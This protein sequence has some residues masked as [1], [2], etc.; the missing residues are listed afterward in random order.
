ML[1]TLF[2]SPKSIGS[3]WHVPAQLH[4]IPGIPSTNFRYNF[5]CFTGGVSWDDQCRVARWFEDTI[6][7]DKERRRE[8]LGILPWIHALTILIASRITAAS[9][10]I[11]TQGADTSED[12]YTAA[13]DQA[14]EIQRGQVTSGSL[15]I[16]ID[17]ECLAFLERRMFLR[18][19]EAGPEAGHYQWGRDAGYHQDNWDPYGTLPEDGRSWSSEDY[20]LHDEDDI[21][22][23]MLINL[24]LMFLLP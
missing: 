17:N 9:K 2:L 19:G 13:L 20:T 10:V 16:D 22:Q 23:V 11:G 1:R 14:W 5:N 4:Q 8:W 18:A 15:Y 24:N 7:H 3:S 21:L 6:V 12:L